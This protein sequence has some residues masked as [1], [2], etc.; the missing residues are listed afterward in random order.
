MKPFIM[1]YL[2]NAVFQL[3]PTYFK[4]ND[5]NIYYVLNRKSKRQISLLRMY[6]EQIF[7]ADDL[8][9]IRIDYLRWIK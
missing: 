6:F 3:L 9:T 1:K 2:L 5:I 7:G 4:N 8:S